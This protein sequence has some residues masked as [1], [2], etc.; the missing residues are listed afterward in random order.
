[1]QSEVSIEA[2]LSHMPEQIIEILCRFND[3]PVFSLNDEAQGTRINI[4]S[5]LKSFEDSVYPIIISNIHKISNATFTRDALTQSR[6]LIDPDCMGPGSYLPLTE[7][8]INTGNRKNQTKT[9]L[10]ISMIP[11]CHIAL[12]DF[13]DEACES[14][15]RYLEDGGDATTLGIQLKDLQ[16]KPWAPT[17][18]TLGKHFSVKDKHSKRRVFEVTKDGP[19]FT[20]D[21]RYRLGTADVH[22]VFGSEPNFFSYSAADDK[23]TNVHL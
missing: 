1:M 13:G 12:E 22:L 21:K 6:L 18:L 7:G 19:G 9:N 10:E 23:M 17:S 15:F 11:E 3:S 16:R 2:Q 5:V 20:N 8:V 4:R 14:L